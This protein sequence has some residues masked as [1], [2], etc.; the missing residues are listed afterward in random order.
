MKR[1][2]PVNCACFQCALKM[3]YIFRE[4]IDIHL[5]LGEVRGSG[6]TAV[7]CAW[8][9]INVTCLTPLIIAA[10]RPVLFALLR[11]TAEVEEGIRRHVKHEPCTT[12]R[13]VEAAEHVARMTVW[14]VLYEDL[15][16]PNHLQRV[17][18]L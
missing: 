11:H 2:F 9:E 1:P 3:E 16:H 7:G 6:A 18:A 4:Y 5:I 12:V 8:R 13:R 15:R 17:Q 10:G 14:W